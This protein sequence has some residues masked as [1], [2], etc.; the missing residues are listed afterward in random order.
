MDGAAGPYVQA[1]QRIASK[2]VIPLVTG[3]FGE[4]NEGL[5]DLI[6]KLA[7]ITANGPQAEGMSPLDNSDRN[8]GTFPIVLHAAL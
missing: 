4:I 7:K 1:L 2:N 3:W 5:N 6:T 8:G